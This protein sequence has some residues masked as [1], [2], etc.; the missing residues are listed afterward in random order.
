LWAPRLIHCSHYKRSSRKIAFVWIAVQVTKHHV[1]FLSHRHPWRRAARIRSLAGE[2]ATKIDGIRNPS[3]ESDA[4]RVAWPRRVARFTP[5]TIPAAGIRV[6][7]IHIPAY[8]G[9]DK[10]YISRSWDWLESTLSGLHDAP[11]IV[12]GDFNVNVDSRRAK[13]GDHF[14]RILANG[15]HRSAPKEQGSYF[16]PNGRRAE[17]HHILCNSGLSLADTR[18]VTEAG[19]FQL[20]G[21]TGALSDH[22]AVLAWCSANRAL[23]SALER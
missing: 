17:I 6:L 10:P 1:R 15:W 13:G 2:L 3:N 5:V 7:G 21:T 11:T 9:E 18:Y 19:G 8:I 14:R 12:A 23:D 20:A 22:A 4:Q 16:G